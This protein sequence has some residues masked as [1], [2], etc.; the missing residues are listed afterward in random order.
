MGSTMS[1]ITECMKEAVSHHQAGRL[2]RAVDLYRMVLSRCPEHPDAQHLIGLISHQQGRHDEA[3][4]QIQKAISHCAT[5]AVYHNNLGAAYRAG[6]RIPE[7]TAAFQNAVSLQPELNSAWINLVGVLNQTGKEKAV[8]HTLDEWVDRSKESVESLQQRAAH[9]Y[10]QGDLGGSISD[11]L[12]ISKL[13][14]ADPAPLLQASILAHEYGDDGLALKTFALARDRY[15]HHSRLGDSTVQS[16][17]NHDVEQF[18]WLV[19]KGYV[20]QEWLVRAQAFKRVNQALFAQDG[21]QLV[22]RALTSE[23]KR[24]I[25]AWYNKP[26]YLVDSPALENGAISTQWCQQEVQTR[27]FASQPGVTWIDGLLRSEAVAQLRNFCMGSTIWSDFKYTGGYVGTS[28]SNGFASG[29]LLQIARELRT[30]LPDLLGRHPLRQMWAYKYDQQLT[31]IGVHADAAAVN[32]N[33]WITPDEA[34]LDA[35]SG[36]LRVWRKCA[37]MDWDFDDF[38]RRP[39]RLMRWVEETGAE[40][41]IVPY[42]SNRA[43]IFDSNLVHRT[44]DFDFA[45]GYENRRINITMLFGRRGG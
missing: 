37:P 9:R 13:H 6:G 18:E 36:G 28:L 23:M 33:F 1:E 16:K 27:Y 30:R 17:L 44:D 42:R 5:V 20:D 15:Y 31:G 4:L 40:E 8:S 21:E 11:Q 45:P 34:N 43:V 41:V 22:G 29:L 32:V 39:Q 2:D 3:A 38:N 24:Q 35:N 7:A 25:G 26:T 14:P 12:R 19:S 10:S